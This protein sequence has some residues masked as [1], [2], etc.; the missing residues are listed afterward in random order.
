MT[1]VPRAVRVACASPHLLIIGGGSRRIRH[2]AQA[3]RTVGS[4]DGVQDPSILVSCRYAGREVKINQT[5]N[6]SASV[7]PSI[8]TPL[9]RRLGTLSCRSFDVY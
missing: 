3:G 1:H 5:R 4:V 8:E 6:S 9:V 7:S 2:A